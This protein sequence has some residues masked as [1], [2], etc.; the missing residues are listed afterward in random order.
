MEIVGL[1]LSYYL[2]KVL[3]TDIINAC[4]GYGW[5]EPLYVKVQRD[6]V[7][8][9]IKRGVEEVILYTELSGKAIRS[10]F[11]TVAQIA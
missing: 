7:N 1:K 9:S 10:S 5:V 8:T 3:T 11:L 4:K 2:L 6:W